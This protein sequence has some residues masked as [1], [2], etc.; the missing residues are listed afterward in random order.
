MFLN[1]K[2]F[3]VVTCDVPVLPGGNDVHVCGSK[4]TIPS[5]FYV[6]VCIHYFEGK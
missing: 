1:I 2:V 5:S 3:I 6:H 4:Q